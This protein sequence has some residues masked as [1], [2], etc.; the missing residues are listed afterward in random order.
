[1]KELMR[2]RITYSLVQ[3]HIQLF[4]TSQ[5]S[6]IHSK[7]LMHPCTHTTTSNT[8]GAVALSVKWP[9]HYDQNSLGSSNMVSKT[10]LN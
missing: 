6:I 2:D 1:M 10:A 5:Q 3:E 7:F 8:S 4:I 9:D